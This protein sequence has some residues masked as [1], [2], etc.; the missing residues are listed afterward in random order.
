[1]PT[2]ISPLKFQQLLIQWQQEHGRHNLPWQKI[3]TPYAVLVSEIMLQQTQ[4]NTVIPYFEKW[5]ARF[6]NLSELAGATDDE[7]MFYWQGLG[8]YSRARNLRKAAQYLMAEHQGE[9][10]RQLETLLKIPGVGRYT[11]GA[12]VSFAFDGF[13]PIVDGN[14][15]R[16]F[17]RLFAIEGVPGTTAVDKQLWQL[18]ET[19][20]PTQNN[21]IFAQGLLDMGATIC[22]PKQPL[23]DQCPFQTDCEAYQ[24]KRVALLPTAKP[25]KQIP[26]KQGQFI[27]CEKDGKIL[28]EKRA[29]AGIWGGLWCLPQIYIEPAQL[30][31]HVP[32]KG[33]FKHTFTHYK[34]DA[35]VWA[36]TD[37]Q[38]QSSSQCWVAFEAVKTYGLPTPIRRFVSQHSS[39]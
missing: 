7:V 6:P 39:D 23:C 36:M 15:K 33:T 4:V 20:T 19:F 30:G 25:K 37:M 31:E 35:K 5:M 34:L 22:K 29:D 26:V 32:L 21:R 14:V 38:L 16:F 11:A 13:G 10:P 24:T 8:Y 1:M 17:C 3:A 27:W 18:A 12:I 28:L 9:F 2:S